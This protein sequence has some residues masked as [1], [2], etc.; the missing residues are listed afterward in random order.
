[1]SFL[2]EATTRRDRIAAY[3]DTHPDF[4]LPTPYDVS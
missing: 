4:R 2:A 1:V 3:L